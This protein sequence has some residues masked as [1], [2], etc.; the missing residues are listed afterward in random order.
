MKITS[1]PLN[2]PAHGVS[3]QRLDAT[4]ALSQGTASGARKD[5]ALSPAARQ[6]AALQDG[7]HDI[8]QARVA[9]LRDAIASGQL[10]IDASRI[11]DG[12]LASYRDLL[13]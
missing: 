12:Q 9:Q 8:D 4:A 11:S 5:V 7:A 2:S 1:S 10:K 13:K 6:L 3:S